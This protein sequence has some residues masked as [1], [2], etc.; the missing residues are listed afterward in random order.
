MKTNQVG[1]DLIAHSEGCK[2]TAYRCPA[3]VLTVGFGH[4]G[5]D[6]HEGMAITADQ[7]KA[8]LAQDLRKFEMGVA[9]YCPVTTE[10]QF[11]ALVSLSYNI[12][13]DNL[14]IS[15]LRR[16]H[17]EGQYSQTADQFLRWN[18]GGGKILPGLVKRRAAERELYLR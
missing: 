15:T 3:G 18:R 2:L 6:V 17:N 11:S 13:L 14:R 16:M 12:G 8:L 9:S 4:T 5:P 10:N 7:A 1:I